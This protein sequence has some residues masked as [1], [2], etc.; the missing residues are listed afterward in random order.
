MG[1]SRRHEAE[2]LNSEI[3]AAGVVL[4][5]AKHRSRFWCFVVSAG[6][7]RISEYKIIRH[8]ATSRLLSVTKVVEGGPRGDEVDLG[9]NTII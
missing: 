4:E 3:V 5:M 2:L 7:K 9:G 6:R 1:V 8:M